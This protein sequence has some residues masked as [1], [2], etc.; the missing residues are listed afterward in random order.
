M[1]KTDNGEKRRKGFSGIVF[2][3]CLF[4]GMGIG[5]LVGHTGGGL[6]TGMGVGFILMG[7]LRAKYGEW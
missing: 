7:L 6:F 1:A 5:M 3:G 2:T 4:L